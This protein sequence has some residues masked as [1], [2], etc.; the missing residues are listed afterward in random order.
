MFE[1][2][3]FAFESRWTQFLCLF[4]LRP[5]EIFPVVWVFSGFINKL[6]SEHS[7]ILLMEISCLCWWSL[8]SQTDLWLC[9]KISRQ[10][11]IRINH[12]FSYI[13]ISK[14]D[15]IGKRNRGGVS[16]NCIPIWRN[17]LL[18][19]NWP[20]SFYSFNLG[21]FKVSLII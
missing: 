17:R 5:V 10:H 3:M 13:F 2:P 21:V 14:C 1:I 7:S 8:L 12:I 9:I 18:I 20:F 4:L 6:L 16:Q 15:I 11:L 19:F